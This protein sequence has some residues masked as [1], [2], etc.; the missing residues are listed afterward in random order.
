MLDIRKGVCPLCEHT[1]IV[2]SVPAD[3]GSKDHER[4]A[5]VTYEPRWVVAGR[6]PNY[7]HGMLR[8]Y[9]CRSCGYVQWFAED[10]GSIPIGDRY[11]TRIISGPAKTEPYR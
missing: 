7:P 8:F 2:E 10:P 1:E 4:T 6:N 3:F 11:L 9:V 5:A